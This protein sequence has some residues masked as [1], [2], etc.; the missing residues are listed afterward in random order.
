MS[1]V[2]SLRSLRSPVALNSVEHKLKHEA[3]LKAQMQ[4]KFLWTEFQKQRK[5]T[6]NKLVHEFK[7]SHVHEK[8]RRT[9]IKSAYLEKIKKLPAQCSFYYDL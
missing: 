2:E 6:Y 9:L 7:A 3:Q 5:S 8:E 1:K 4:R